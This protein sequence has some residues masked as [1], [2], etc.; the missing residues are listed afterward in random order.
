MSFFK[1]SWD[2]PGDSA[3]PGPPWTGG[4][5]CH[6]DVYERGRPGEPGH[7]PMHGAAL[8]VLEQ[9]DMGGLAQAP[10]QLTGLLHQHVRGYNRQV[11]GQQ[12]VA[13]DSLGRVALAVTP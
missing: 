2:C 13:A 8:L 3:I 5:S 10:G 6:G 12:L 11:E 4:G 1:T 7:R 9:G